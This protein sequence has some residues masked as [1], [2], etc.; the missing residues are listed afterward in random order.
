MPSVCLRGVKEA[1]VSAAK[2]WRGRGGEKAKRPDGV[3]SSR[4]RQE[5]LNRELVTWFCSAGTRAQ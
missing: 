5:M 4:G 1:R 2:Q 3:G